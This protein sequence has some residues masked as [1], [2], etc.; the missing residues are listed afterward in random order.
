[1]MKAKEAKPKKT[2]EIPRA[3]ISQ[4]LPALIAENPVMNS[5]P[6]LQ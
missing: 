1:M 6:L 2:T 4:P 3:E 5:T